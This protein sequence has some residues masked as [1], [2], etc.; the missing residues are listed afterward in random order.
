MSRFFQ[1]LLGLAS[2][3]P[4]FQ[5]TSITSQGMVSRL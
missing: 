3:E 4:P 2:S 1:F 5:P